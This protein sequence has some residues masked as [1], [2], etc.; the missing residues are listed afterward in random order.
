MTCK[1]STAWLMLAILLTG[2]LTGCDIAGFIGQGISG[3]KVVKVGPEY[4]KLAGKSVAVMVAADEQTLFGHPGAPLAISRA[5]SSQLAADIKDATLSDPVQVIDFQRKNP[6]WMTLPY[7]QLA[8]R[9]NVDRVILIDLIQYSTHEPGNTHVWRGTAIANVG[10][11][12]ADAENPNNLVYQQNIRVQFPENQP[13]GVLDSDDA[14]I[15]LGLVK[16]MGLRIARLFVEHEEV[17][18]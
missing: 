8:K 14:S 16:D 4:N 9:M 5:V 1:R 3:P 18:P 17:R 10:V 6:Y 15:Q 2:V 7:G 13:V 12:E 11:I